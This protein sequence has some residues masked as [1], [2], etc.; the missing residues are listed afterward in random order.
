MI[1]RR[2]TGGGDFRLMYSRFLAEAGREE[3]ALAAGAAARWTELA[4][5]F[6][7]ASE[8]DDAGRAVER[9]RRRPTRT[10]PADGRGRRDRS[11][12]AAAAA[13][14]RRPPRSCRG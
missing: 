3:A 2:G 6:L 1:E 12:R 10:A 8:S 4:E 11:A 14:E 5:V 13:E 7:A 9:D